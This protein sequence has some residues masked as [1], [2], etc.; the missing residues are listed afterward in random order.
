M[1]HNAGRARAPSPRN[2]PELSYAPGSPERVELGSELTRMAGDFVEMPCIIDGRPVLTGVLE[3]AR[4][5]HDHAHCLGHA[6]LAGE[7]EVESAI[8][9]ALAAKA[10][11][12]AWPADARAAVFLRA[13]ERLSR[14]WRQTLNAATMLG[15]S[16]NVQQ[17][18]V[19]SA[20]ELIDF[21][22]FNVEFMQSVLAQQ[23]QNTDGAWTHVDYRPLEGFVYA[24]SPFNFTAIAGNLPSAPALMGNTVLWKPSPA[25]KLSAHY[26]MQL[27]V[28]S[29]LP[30][31]V[32]NLVYGDAQRVTRV[33]MSHPMLAGVHFTGS[34][35]VFAELQ[36]S[37]AKGRYRSIPRIVGETGGKNFILAHPS[38]DIDS[39]VPAI[40]RGAFEY[41]GQKCSAPSR[42]YIPESLWPRLRERLCDEMA[43]IRMGDVRDF[44]NFMT[45]VIHE[46]A[47]QR[48]NGL[49]Q[50]AASDPAIRILA[51]GG[52]DM[53]TGYFVE[54]TLLQTDD[55]RHRF[56]KEEF[57]GPITTAY[58]YPD[59]TYSDVL[60]TIDGFADYALT[61][62]VFST[63]R[64]AILEACGRLRYSAGNLYVNDKPTGA[65]VGQQPFGGSRASGTNDK[66]GSIWNMA[67]WTSPRTI[68]ERFDVPGDGYAHAFMTPDRDR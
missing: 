68:K 45:A 42:L 5:P 53:K 22:R 1:L 37:A 25:A 56:M 43:T 10:E 17:A 8:R 60:E 54:P 9:A 55:P 30:D 49:L 31:G 12:A 64:A 62:S 24:A 3:A 23:P 28:E 35:Q 50:A 52:T 58:V 4:M 26:I 32:I 33:A 16:K 21:W 44:S 65:M 57:F 13:A 63:D 27:L 38:A 66:A 18:E 34:T 29:G 40:I 59:Q 39:L 7:G 6:H 19:D 61:G 15:Q 48:H 20:C 11:W 14:Q 51:G 46:Q 2:E 47:W 36:R 67:R 41:Q